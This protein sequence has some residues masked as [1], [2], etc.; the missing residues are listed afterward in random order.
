[1]SS[2]IP[3]AIAVLGAVSMFLIAISLRPSTNLL[4]T[5]IRKLERVSEPSLSQRA[6]IVDHI[7]STEHKSNL[8]SQLNEA[9]WY[10]VTPVALALRGIGA[11]GIG[12]SVA[13]LLIIVLHNNTLAAVMGVAIALISWR[14][15]NI[16]LSRAIK[17]RKEQIARDLPEFLDLLSTTV[18]A[19]LAL[20]AALIQSAD[21]TSGPLRNELDST[22][23]EIRLGR[24]R[25][26]ALNA[27]ADRANETSLSMSVSAIV[28]AEK[29]GIDLGGVLVEVAKE[30]RDRRWMRAEEQAAQLP[31]KMI[32]PM[33]FFMIP[34]LYLMIF[35][36]V[37][38]EF[39]NRR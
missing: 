31:I 14:I 26:E 4:K 18:Q 3:F 39:V 29:L 17:A 23:S 20:N 37:I 11:Y 1:V 9:G 27:M 13:I 38:A 8:R 36:P 28:Q 24:S 34:S 35:G 7:V 25:T 33:V 16:V 10:E 5:R 30:S 22:I 19:G 12:L 6:A 2:L 21:A 15:P 32:I